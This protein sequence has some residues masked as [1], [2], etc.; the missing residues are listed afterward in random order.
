[1]RHPVFVLLT[2]KAELEIQA[3]PRLRCQV[4]NRYK[5]IRLADDL[6][7]HALYFSSNNAFPSGNYEI[8]MTCMY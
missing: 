1:M 6:D 3:P 5:K 7:S 8:G 2:I 4:E